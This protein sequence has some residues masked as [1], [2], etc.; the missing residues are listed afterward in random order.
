MSAALPELAAPR[1]PS[2]I[3]RWLRP[4]GLSEI[5][6]R[7]R[8]DLLLIAA[9]AWLAPL[10]PKLVAAWPLILKGG[11][12]L[13][14]SP[15]SAIGLAFAA[16]VS[17]G[18]NIGLFAA[19]WT[20]RKWARHLTTFLLGGAGLAQFLDGLV[21]RPA[22]GLGIGGTLLTGAMYVAGAVML[23]SSSVKAFLETR[24]DRVRFPRP[25]GRDQEA[26]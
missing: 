24:Q 13:A 25:R 9:G 10:V 12:L 23:Q 5:A 6:Q 14:A 3:E 4:P 7:G 1:G 20:G 15:R 19:V 22:A 8:R 17:A 26:G 16:A 2:T 11:E 21:G 18:V